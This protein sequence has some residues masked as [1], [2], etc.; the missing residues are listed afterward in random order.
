MSMIRVVLATLLGLTTL[1]FS[2][3]AL[4][5]GTHTFY[6]SP[7]GSDAGDGLSAASAW[8]TVGKVNGSALGPGDTVLFERGGQ[9][10]ESLVAPASGAAG[11]PITFADYGSGTKPKFWGSV[12]LDNGSFEPLGYGIYAYPMTT[13]VYSVLADHGF[14]NYAFGQYVGNVAGAWA[15]DGTRIFVNSP[16]SDPRYDGRVYTAVE[17]DDV[18]YSNG[19]SHLV[20]RNLVVDE[21]ARYD[22]N[23]GYGF[24]V[25]GSTDVQVAGCEAYR[26]GKH[27]FGVIN[28]TAFVGRDL[29]AAYAAPGQQSSGGASAYVSYGDASTGLYNQTSEWHNVSASNMDD[30]EEASVYQAFTDHGP[31]VGSVWLDGLTSNGA[32]VTV[33]NQENTAATIKMTGGSIQ[34]ARLEI[35]GDGVLVDGVEISGAQ[36]SVDLAA[37]D[38]VLQNMLIHGTNLGGAWYQTAVLSRGTGNTLRFSTIDVDGGAGT[39]TCVA[40]TNA[41]G[42][43]RMYANVLLAPHR[44]FAL[45]DEG[46]ST[47]TVAQSSYN[48][49][50]TGRTFASFVGGEFQWS[51]LSLAQW[52]ADG[53]DAGSLNGDPRFVRNAPNADYHPGAGSPLIDAAQLPG[54]LLAVVP[55]DFAGS[56]RLQGA[57]FDIGAYE[58]TASVVRLAASTTTLNFSGGILNA[59]VV[60]SGGTPTGAVNFFDG[61]TLLNTV[62]LSGGGAS[63]AVSLDSTVGHSLTAVYGGD[64]NYKGSASA[65]ISVDPVIVPVPVA[66]VPVVPAPVPVVPVPVI[67]V[68]PVIPTPVAPITP[69]P[70]AP[71]VPVQSYPIALTD[72]VDG[73]SVSGTVVVMATIPMTLDA[74]GSFLI[75]DGVYLSNYRVD[76]GP[77]L[78]PLDTTQLPNGLHTIQI[79]A[80][81]TGNVVNLSNPVTVL[82]SN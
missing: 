80:H 18:V 23:G 55:T 56:L 8:R 82:V 73:Q 44:V 77:Y 41:N 10:R 26:A 1:S 11:Q 15:Y 7:A 36:G 5:Q 79:W 34:N 3:P 67:P 22:D 33:S 16:G 30:A 46:L 42:G 6:V 45:W 59:Q 29:V 52:Q 38:T 53:F 58:G 81:D 74:A 28:S 9:W 4:A 70:V 20:F 12:V 25:E 48:Y 76:S 65:A 62:P 50:A 40:T 61:T 39:N 78:Y 21:S 49:Y 72:P 37:S 32:G 71:V 66:P 51:D 63:S 17:R 43:L 54:S 2:S 75:V 35:D 24:R 31:T 27:H 60:G 47:A 57:A 13:P 69:T 14:F 19:K 68:A 64:G